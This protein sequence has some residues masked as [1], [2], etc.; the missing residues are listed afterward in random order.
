M[1][2]GEEDGVRRWEWAEWVRLFR[3]RKWGRSWQI[4]GGVEGNSGIGRRRGI[5]GGGR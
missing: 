2:D 5:V 3:Q 4:E 1:R